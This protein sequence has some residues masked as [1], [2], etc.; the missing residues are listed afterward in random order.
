MADDNPHFI[1]FSCLFFGVFF[2]DFRYITLSLDPV[3]ALRNRFS[4]FAHILKGRLLISSEI[5]LLENA[6][7]KNF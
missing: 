1:R 7:Q 5:K 2:F 6:L 4:V 3:F